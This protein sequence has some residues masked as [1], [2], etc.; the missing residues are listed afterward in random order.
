M[1]VDTIEANFFEQTGILP[2]KRKRDI[3]KEERNAKKGSKPLAP[4]N[5]SQELLFKAIRTKSQI[6]TI[7]EAGTGKTYVSAR[8]A[9][10]ELVSKRIDK[11]F[12]ARPTVSDKRHKQ[13]FL[14]GKLDQK[15][16]PWLVPIMDAFK[17]ELSA[18]QL[19]VFH[20]EKKIEFLSFEHLRGRTLGNCWAILDE[21]QNCTFGDLRLFLTRK[22]E[23]SKFIITGDPVQVDIEDSGLWDIVEMIRKY[24]L[25]P[26]IVEFDENDVV[27]SADAKEW[28]T[29]FKRFT[30]ERAN[31]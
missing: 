22:G 18:E 26:A 13:G 8:H 27:R 17:D 7:G 23:N 31:A 16:E 2:P 6:V 4:L 3:I 25:S 5:P 10:R 11:I 14:P 9:A 30:N 29:A 19:R 24:E 28:V 12:M 1:F 21:A 20:N 15:L